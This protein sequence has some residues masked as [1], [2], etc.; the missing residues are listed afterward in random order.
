MT[1]SEVM[2]AHKWAHKA[3]DESHWDLGTCQQLVI[4]PSGLLE[5]V[6]KGFSNLHGYWLKQAE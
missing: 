2:S 4:P 3:G 5:R 1:S 6:L